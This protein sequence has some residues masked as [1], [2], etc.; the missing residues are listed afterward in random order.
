MHT[1][2]YNDDESHPGFPENP[3]EDKPLDKLDCR[4]DHLLEYGYKDFYKEMRMTD[5]RGYI[6][7]VSK[8][9]DGKAIRRVLVKLR[10]ILPDQKDEEIEPF[11]WPK[12]EVQAMI[13]FLEKQVA[14]CEKTGKAICFMI[15]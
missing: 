15:C 4:P 12:R 6:T 2:E 13:K 5:D 8:R 11:W 3:D 1:Y 14:W 9:M 10:Y 7:G